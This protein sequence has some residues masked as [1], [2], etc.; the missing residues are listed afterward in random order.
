[1]VAHGGTR[2]MTAV[3]FINKLPLL[4]VTRPPS[5]PIHTH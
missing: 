1:M 2:G 4:E 5:L 3:L